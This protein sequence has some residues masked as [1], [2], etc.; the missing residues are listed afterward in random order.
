VL[1]ALAICL[2]V[3]LENLYEIIWFLLSIRGYGNFQRIILYILPFSSE[4]HLCI[5][6]AFM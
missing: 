6:G 4:L 3:K 2:L 1:L 5:Y